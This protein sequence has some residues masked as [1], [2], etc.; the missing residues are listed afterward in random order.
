MGAF[1]YFW[2]LMRN[3]GAILRSEPPPG[4]AEVFV[5]YAKLKLK[6]LVPRRPGSEKIFGFK[7]NFLDYA[8]F[9]MLFEEQ[10]IN[11]EYVFHSKAAEPFIIDC[12]SNI[13]MSLVFFKKL[14]PNSRI[15]AFEPDE[16]AFETLKSNVESNGM[17]NVELHRAAITERHGNVDF[18]YDA[19][20]PGKAYMTTRPGRIARK[21]VEKVESTTL[22]E[23][24][25]RPVD[26]LKMDI[27][28]AETGAIKELSDNG[29]LRLV[30]EMV[31]EYHHHIVPGEDAFSGIL[32][33]LEENGFGYSIHTMSGL[34]FAKNRS[35]EL[36]ILISAYRKEEKN[37]GKQ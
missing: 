16:K 32:G 23:Y 36:C 35:A 12:G 9:V 2:L 14:Y 24:I 15:I 4:R 19:E 37:G 3:V 21:G 7:V 1:G 13:G 18:Y 30:S 33:I 27:E 22:S 6:G 11:K 25:S 17:K 28:G 26:F 5:N 29:K 8:D 20:K 10:F 34:P 31:I